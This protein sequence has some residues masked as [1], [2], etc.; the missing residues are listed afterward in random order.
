MFKCCE[1][2]FRFCKGFRARQEGDFSAALAFGITNFLE[3]PICIA[4]REA[5]EMCAAIAVDRKL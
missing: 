1:I 5:H 3:R 2:K 4:M